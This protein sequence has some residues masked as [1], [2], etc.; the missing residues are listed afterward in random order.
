[1]KNRFLLVVAVLLALVVGASAQAGIAQFSA[2]MT[3]HSN[4]GRRGPADMT[5]KF[6]FGGQKMRWDMNAEHGEVSMITDLAAKKSYTVMHEQK[7]YMEHDLNRPMGMM[8][9]PKPP[10]VRQYDPANPCANEPSTTCKKVGTETVNGRSCDK[11]EFTKDGK[12]DSTVWVDQKIHIPV[13]MVHADGTTFEMTNIKE[14]P[15]PANLFEVPSGYQ[16]FDMGQMMRGMGH[17]Q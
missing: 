16:K 13:K 7:M 17:D 12:L 2:D 15:Q 14:G 10:D 4:G 5:G 9:G 1:M 6:Y 11:W 8:R 3:V